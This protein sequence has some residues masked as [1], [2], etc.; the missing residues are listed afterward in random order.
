[1]RKEVI[2]ILG[3]LILLISFVNARSEFADVNGHKVEF[4]DDKPMTAN[5]NDIEIISDKGLYTCTGFPNADGECLIKGNFTIR[6]NREN[7]INIDTEQLFTTNVKNIR[8]YNSEQG[9][10]KFNAKSPKEKDKKTTKLQLKKA[11]ETVYSFEFWTKVDGKFDIEI[12]IYQQ[13][14][15][16]L[17]AT[18]ILDPLYQVDYSPAPAL[19]YQ[20]GNKTEPI[21]DSFDAPT[22][23]TAIMSDNNTGT[24]VDL[25]SDPSHGEDR[26][27]RIRFDEPYQEG[28]T[29]WIAIYRP[30]S[31]SWTAKVL[32]HINSTHVN[33]SYYVTKMISGTGWHYI[34]VTGITEFMDT[35]LGY[36]DY[37]VQVVPDNQITFSEAWLREEANDTIYPSIDSCYVTSTA[38]GCDENVTF[39]CNVSD[40]ILV[41]NATFTI[42]G[43][44]YVGIKNE[45][46]YYFT[47]T[48]SG[49]KIENHTLD[50][51]E[52]CDLFAQC[53]NES[54]TLWS[55]FTCILCNES[56]QPAN[57]T[58]IC[59]LNDSVAQTLVY[60]DANACGTTINLPIDNGSVTWQ[61]CNYCVPDIQPVQG[62][63]IAG[64]RNN[65]YTDNDYYACCALTGFVPDC[66]V[67][68]SPY[69]ETTQESCVDINNSMDCD[70]SSFAEFGF[71]EDKIYWVCEP[72][73][74]TG[75]CLSY[76]LDSSVGVIQVNPQKKTKSNSFIAINSDTEERTSF[77]IE[78]GLVNVY[79]TNE[80]MVFDNREYGFKVVCSNGNTTTEFTELYNSEYENIKAPVTRWFWFRDNMFAVGLGLI[81]TIFLI[82][83]VSWIYKGAW[84]R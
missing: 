27:I 5:E 11:E 42:D 46:Q 33:M 22:N 43:T 53:T 55:E 32:P 30:F 1:M 72:Q 75:S 82:V 62:S 52:V 48:D 70:T 38:F 35:N 9:E 81:L 41:E 36:L 61:Y 74:N 23:I 49:S 4:F 79:F 29:Y 21:Y 6:N 66:A 54:Q 51:V 40:D 57:I 84:K 39:I 58:G 24:T 20:N 13:G 10:T 25:N 19:W 73:M 50:S 69:N 76:V 45:T 16:N 59:Q 15:E 80:N 8:Y 77:E 34:N 64:I 83:L 78:N 17:L 71:F 3:M 14:N 67:D 7:T 65:T 47:L 2:I 37:R 28:Y 60:T 18:T 12:N 63:C 44:D 56:W 68:Y 26:L 31:T